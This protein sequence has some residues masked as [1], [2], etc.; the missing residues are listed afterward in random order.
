VQPFTVLEVDPQG[1][2][3]LSLLREAA[4]EA[5]AL[6]PELIEKDA[7][8]PTNGPN[9]EGGIYL[10]A[11]QG[12]IPVGC[13]ALRPLEPRVAEV[14]RMFVSRPGRRCGVARQVLGELE[15]R[16]RGLG[17]TALRLETGYKQVPAI[18]LYESAGFSRIE[19]FGV[20]VGDPTSVCFHKDIGHEEGDA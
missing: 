10:V 13:G 9:P 15:A 19:P 17:Y 8:W 4:V 18:K 14:R 20:Y 6:Y 11:Y 1:S 2:D 7:P 16:A 3:A 12:T 5:R